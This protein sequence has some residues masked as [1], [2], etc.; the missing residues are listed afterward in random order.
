M[1][2]LKSLIVETQSAFRADPAAAQAVFASHSQLKEGFHS[3]ATLGDHKVTVDEPASLGGTNKGPNPVELVLAALGTCQ[4]IT[5]RAYATALGIP[6]DGVR[7]E[8]TGDLD[9]RGFFAVDDSV[10]PGYQ[11]IRGTWTSARTLAAAASDARR[12]RQKSPRRR[13]RAMLGT[14]PSPAWSKRCA[15]AHVRHAS[16]CTA[17]ALPRVT[18]PNALNSRA[19]RLRAPAERRRRAPRTAATAGFPVDLK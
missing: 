2:D 17:V 5:Y 11:G 9:L 8:L 4:E 16:S 15:T 3:V 19:K 14:V 18:V 7:V 10:R 1:S 6:L 12:M 13:R